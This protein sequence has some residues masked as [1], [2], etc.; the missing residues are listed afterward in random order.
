MTLL[1][2]AVQITPKS[3]PIT[4]CLSFPLNFYV[5]A[6]DPLSAGGA[7]DLKS[8]D[9]TEFSGPNN[10]KIDTHNDIHVISNFDVTAGGG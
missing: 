7:A 8:Y 3:T 10:P 9:I 2:S 1:K 6:G 4:I 5:T